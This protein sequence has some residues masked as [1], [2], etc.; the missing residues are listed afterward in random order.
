MKYRM[1]NEEELTHL[2]EE[3]KQFLIVNGVH[4]EEWERLNRDEPAKA[5]QLVELFSD[6]VLQK[7]YE[8]MKV[9]EF[10]S[11]D[12]CMVFHYGED[13]IDLISIQAK[14]NTNV[15]LSTPE[16]I[17]DAL[18]KKSEELNYFRSGKKYKEEREMELHKM[19]VQGCIPS[20]NEFWIFL[21]NA[22]PR[23]ST[24]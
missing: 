5:I 9:I 20:S 18:T 23:T 14:P 17:H 22:I 10:R 21:D 12:S 2:E 8:K 13:A 15:D 4:G 24:P 16:S 1:L 3:L 7:V 19:L 6:N 11:K